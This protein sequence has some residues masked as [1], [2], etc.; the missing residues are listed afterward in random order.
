HNSNDLAEFKGLPSVRKIKNVLKAIRK[1]LRVDPGNVFDTEPIAAQGIHDKHCCL[2]TKVVGALKK[3]IHM[4]VDD[5]D[6]EE[7]EEEEEEEEDKDK[8]SDTSEM[9]I[10]EMHDIV[11]KL[12]SSK[13]KSKKFLASLLKHK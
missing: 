4:E 5:N 12:L 1:M 9:S 8:D 11:K 3:K 13:K 2:E 7:E 10:S 6:K